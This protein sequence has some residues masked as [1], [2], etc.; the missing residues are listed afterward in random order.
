MK[1]FVHKCYAPRREVIPV[2]A[3]ETLSE[4]IRTKVCY[5]GAVCAACGGAVYFRQ[6]VARQASGYRGAHQCPIGEKQVP[7]NVCRSCLCLSQGG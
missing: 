6:Q 5:I 7:R 2:E 3:H 4:M 1:S